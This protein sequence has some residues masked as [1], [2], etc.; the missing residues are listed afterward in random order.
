[1]DQVMHAST[2]VYRPLVTCDSTILTYRE[3]SP[4]IKTTMISEHENTM[5]TVH[6]HSIYIFLAETRI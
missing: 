4:V 3:V 2:R 6:E 1:M 5:R